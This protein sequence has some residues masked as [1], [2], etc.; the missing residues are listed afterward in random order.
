MLG[1]L[2]GSFL[3]VVIH[4][5]PRMM[6]RAE[7]NY[8]ASLRNEPLPYRDRFDL[9]MPRS[10]CPDCQ[11]PVAHRHNVPVIGFLLL[12][13]RCGACGAPIGWRYPAVE[14]TGAAVA[15]AALWQLGPTWQAAAGMVLGW[16]LL[17]LAL[18][19]A[20]SLLL[21]DQITQPLLW[22]GLLV[23]VWGLFVPATDAIVGAAGGYLMLWG[24]YW[25]F[26]LLRGKEGMGY[27]DFKL[28]AALGGWFGWQALP[29]LL[30][31]SSLAGL[32]C[33]LGTGLVRSLDRDRP[34]PFGPCLAVAG[35]LVLLGG[36][37]WLL[38]V[39]AAA[40]PWVR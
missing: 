12:R 21:P 1:L 32:V 30:L 14:V 3:N 25:L 10:H 40:F 4:R 5:L 29:A 26:K 23:N 9:A 22:L 19:D 35:I 20:E 6:E 13:G 31:L 7:A 36:D 2:V 18:I 11:R 16:S 33:A 38:R 27:G 28:M 37:D 17:A 34:L 8:V 24:V 15:A 39:I